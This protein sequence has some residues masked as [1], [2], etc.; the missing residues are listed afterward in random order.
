M[1]S[2]GQRKKETATHELRFAYNG[3]NLIATLN[4]E[5]STGD[6]FARGATA[7]APTKLSFWQFPVPSPRMHL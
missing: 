3:W 2:L 1:I 5:F 7:V 6:T 4:S